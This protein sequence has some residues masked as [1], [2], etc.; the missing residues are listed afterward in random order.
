[1]YRKHCGKSRNCS[2]RAISPFPPVF[3]EDLSCRHV[4]KT[5]F[6]WKRVKKKKKKKK[7]EQVISRQDL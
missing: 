6:V 7:E 1:M 2:L 3:S 5:G 4:K